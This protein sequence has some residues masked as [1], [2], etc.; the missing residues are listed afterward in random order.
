MGCGLYQCV[1][2][3]HSLKRCTTLTKHEKVINLIKD[4]CIETGVG[5]VIVSCGEDWYSTIPKLKRLGF[6]EL[7]EYHN[8]RHGDNYQQKLFILKIK[9][10]S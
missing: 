5:A 3:V 1:N 4:Y 8:Y 10:E 7:S 6:I 9:K 2:L